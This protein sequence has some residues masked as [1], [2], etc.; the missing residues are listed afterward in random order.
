MRKAFYV[1]CFISLSCF[2]LGWTLFIL[3]LLD[4]S[5]ATLGTE[6]SIVSIVLVLLG[7]VTLLCG[8]V[9]LLCRFVIWLIRKLRQ[10]KK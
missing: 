10:K 2:L 3:P 5:F 6:L 8:L 1:F 7:F 4:R 9:I